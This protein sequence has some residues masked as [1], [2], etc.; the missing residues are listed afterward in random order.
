V[1]TARDAAPVNHA[2]PHSQDRNN[3]MDDLKHIATPTTRPAVVTTP[4]DAPAKPRVHVGIDLAKLSFQAAADADEQ[5]ARFNLAFSYD[6]AG[7]TQLL[8]RLAQL[9]V[10][11]I[12]M[13]ATGG[14]E[15]KLAAELAEAGYAIAIINPRQARDFAKAKGTLAKTDKVDAQILAE[16]A[17][18]LRPR[19]KPPAS[20]KQLR[21][22]DLVARRR[23]LMHMRTQE[24]NRSHQA[25]QK[26]VHNDIKDSIRSLTR[27][28]EKIEKEITRLIDSDSDWK[29]K[30]DILDSAPGVGADTAHAL[31]AEIPELGTLSKREVASLA[32]LAPYPFESG[33]FRGQSRIWGGRAYARAALYMATLTA[34]KHNPLIKRFYQSLLARGKKKILA[35]TACMRK[36]LTILNALVR[37]GVCWNENVTAYNH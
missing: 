23:Q 36:L 35:L 20:E 10:A 21:L 2:S 17:R 6:D 28:I 25:H 30:S 24:Q 12:V 22:K 14:L 29:N 8:E 5:A 33:Q 3:V 13:E 11:L 34:S 32:G 16:L 18:I 9:D 31:L 15:R 26:D 27:R 19:A 1:N 4:A 7:I 37:K